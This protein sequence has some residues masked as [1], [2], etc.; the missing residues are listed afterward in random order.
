[1]VVIGLWMSEEPNARSAA[2]D[3]HNTLALAI[4][5]QRVSGIRVVGDLLY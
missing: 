2:I 5:Q 3:L 1:M 4:I